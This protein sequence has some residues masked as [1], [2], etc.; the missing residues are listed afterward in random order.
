MKAVRL[1]CSLLIV[2]SNS[3][4]Q[5]SHK[6]AFE[7][8]IHEYNLYNSNNYRITCD[9]IVVNKENEF[10]ILD[11]K[12]AVKL[13]RKITGRE[14]IAFEEYLRSVSFDTLK[15]SY[16]NN[17]AHAHGYDYDFVII[18]GGSEHKVHVYESNVKAMRN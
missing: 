1:V 12:P 18:A 10:R 13:R 4:A 11:N 3:Y 15:L 6:C 9:S 14:S 16:V 5:N 17:E 7:I 2:I 8:I